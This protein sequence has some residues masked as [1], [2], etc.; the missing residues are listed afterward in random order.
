MQ[1]TASSD[2][3]FWLVKNTQPLCRAGWTCQGVNPQ[4]KPPSHNESV[5]ANTHPTRDTTSRCCLYSPGCPQWGAAHE[6]TVYWLPFLPYLTS[7]F[8]TRASCGHLPK[9]LL[10]LTS[11]SQV[12]GLG[13][14][15][16]KTGHR[17]LGRHDRTPIQTGR[18]NV[19]SLLNQGPLQHAMMDPLQ[20]PLA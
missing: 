10:A 15:Q 4:E 5:L 17:V 8:P 12:H 19:A 14:I 9:K 16:V 1:E 11:L 6:C 13:G 2:G 18:V 3:Y 20:L 7:L